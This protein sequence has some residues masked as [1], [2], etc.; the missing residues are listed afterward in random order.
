MVKKKGKLNC[1]LPW[2]SGPNGCVGNPDRFKPLDEM[3]RLIS[4]I[5]SD[6]QADQE[7]PE[8]KS[9]NSAVDS[10]TG[11]GAELTGLCAFYCSPHN[12]LPSH[13]DS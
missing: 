8:I 7:Q 12:K 13:F 5:L 3:R 11:F 10:P 1:N 9:V 4:K 6:Y 2:R